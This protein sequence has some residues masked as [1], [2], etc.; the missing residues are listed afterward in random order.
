MQVHFVKPNNCFITK[1]PRIIQ[2]FN[3]FFRDLKW[4]LNINIIKLSKGGYLKNV[5]RCRRYAENVT[6]SDIFCST[7]TFTLD[8]C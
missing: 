6:M 8:I 2:M 4:G 3:V 1:I 7:S 5:S